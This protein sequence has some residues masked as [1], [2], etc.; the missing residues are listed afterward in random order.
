[1]ARLSVPPRFCVRSGTSRIPRNFRTACQNESFR[2]GR[3]QRDF[4]PPSVR[5]RKGAAFRHLYDFALV[6]EHREHTSISG[7]SVRD[8]VSVSSF[9][10]LDSSLLHDVDKL[11][12]SS[13][14]YMIWPSF[15]VVANRP[16]FPGRLTLWVFSSISSLGTHE[17]V[18]SRVREA[19][20]SNMVLICDISVEQLC[21]HFQHHCAPPRQKFPVRV[22]IDP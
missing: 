6:K 21:A 12:S 16:Q 2:I 22:C 4:F 8:R 18:A 11:V 13:G 9:L 14:L 15:T 3:P 10:A 7:S 20:T 17:R 1:M 5:E 19:V